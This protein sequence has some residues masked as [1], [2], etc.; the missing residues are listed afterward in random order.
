MGGNDPALRICLPRRTHHQMAPARQRLCQVTSVGHHAIRFGVN[1][2][3]DEGLGLLQL[4]AS[5]PRGLPVTASARLA[6]PTARAES[7]PVLKLL[8]LILPLG[9]DTFAVSAA[10]AMRGLPKR[11]RM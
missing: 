4:D 10:L 2:V 1:S 3:K 6:S 9:W 7:L 5:T 8:L 11:E